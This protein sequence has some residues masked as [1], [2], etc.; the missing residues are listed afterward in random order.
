MTSNTSKETIGTWII[1]HG[2]KITMD[3]LGPSEFPAIDEASK[4]VHLLS[5][6]GE[7]NNATLKQAEGAGSCKS[8]SPQPTP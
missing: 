2:R 1:H 8:C 5:G 4:A 3:A 6:L 7:T